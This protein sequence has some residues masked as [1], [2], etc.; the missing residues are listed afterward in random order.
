[1]ASA[2]FAVFDVVRENHL[3]HGV[4][5]V[6]FEE[7]VL[8]ARE[9]DARGAE[10]HGVFGLL[11]GVG[12]GADLELGDL[13]APVHQGGKLCVGVALLA[14]EGLL[15]EHLNDLGGGGRELAGINVAAR[16]VDG[17]EVAFLVGHAVRREGLGGVIN[18]ERAG[19]A[20]A[21]FAHLAGDQRR[22]RAD[23]AFGGED[24]FGGDHAAQVF[25][26]G[27]VADEENL[28][29]L[30]GG[31]VGAV[32]VQIELAGGGA[33]TGGQALGDDLGGLLALCASKIGARSWSS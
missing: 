15:D 4:N 12:V 29:A 16:A 22:V 14:V 32:G 11:G 23:A 19:A 5:A 18:L 2:F 24:A 6:A 30:G 13:R 1:M 7:H 26:R 20:D 17:E 28:L 33:R 10:R 31:R 27:F 3:A 25:G 9:A 8:G 21:D